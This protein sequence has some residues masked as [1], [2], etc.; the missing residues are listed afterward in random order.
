MAYDVRQKADIVGTHRFICVRLM[1]TLARWVPTTPELE[2]K[3]L[4]GRHLWDLA[5]HADQFGQRTAE[6]RAGL[7]HSREPARGFLDVLESFANT[8]D[9]TRRI[10]GF[11]DAVLPFLST[12]YETYLE[13][14]DDL[15]DEPTVRILHRLLADHPRMRAQRDELLG[16]RPDLV[17]D[18]KTF[19]NDLR[20][21]LDA[22]GEVVN[23]RA[24]PAGANR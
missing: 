4:F 8:K 20:R 10:D 21:S 2:A 9:T 23:Y 14:T 7:H 15:L 24:Q 5:Q 1:E 13:N 17:A 22:A 6:L 12:A 16:E 18:D 11:Y 3:A 19:S